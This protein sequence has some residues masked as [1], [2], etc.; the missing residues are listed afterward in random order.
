MP[1]PEYWRNWLEG[2][3]FFGAEGSGATVGDFD[4]LDGGTHAAASVE[5]GTWFDNKLAGEDIAMNGRGRLQHEQLAD[6]EFAFYFTFNVCILC[7]DV[8]I[9]VTCISEGNFGFRLDVAD[10]FAVD[11][12]V[13]ERLDVSLERCTSPNRRVRVHEFLGHTFLFL[14]CKHL[15]SLK[16][17]KF[18]RIKGTAIV[19]QL[20][21]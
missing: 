12:D 8:S 18:F 21:V 19:P 5:N 2:F 10:D 17:Y 13:A 11:A 9:D 14:R 1:R 4:V 16:G 20:E 15:V 3:C 6:F 7:R